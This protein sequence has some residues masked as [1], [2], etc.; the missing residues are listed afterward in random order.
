MSFKS[1]SGYGGLETT[2]LARVGYHDKVIAL[3]W[4]KDFLPEIT[5]SQ[6]NERVIDCNSTVQIMKQPQ[7]G[8]W[9]LYEKN[10][11]L[12][13]N[14]VSAEGVCL[15]ICN[16]AYNAFKFDKMD[17]AFACDRWDAWE[18]MFLD[19]SYRTLVEMW[20]TY[21]LTSMIL[22]TS[23]KNKGARAGRYGNI[24]LG[25]SGAPVQVTPATLPLHLAR[26]Q[27]V[28]KEFHRWDEGKMFI[29]V[30][31][32]MMEVLVQSNYANNA[33]TGDCVPCSIAIDGM[34]N[35]TLMGFKVIE[36]S[37]SPSA[38]DS[39]GQLA[40]YVI[41][42]NIDAYAWYAD[43]IEGRIVN[44]QQTFGIQYQMLSVWGGKM[45]YDDAMAI[46]YWTFG[47]N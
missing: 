10:Q 7:V 12:I 5:N 46:G 33:W 9:R 40:Y 28:L 39:T 35:K 29:V 47:E 45:L 4:E 44:M 18:S 14:Q 11:E 20:R 27:R 41:A 23:R 8:P 15:E 13:P 19:S 21:V 3:A 26:L 2:P 36:T 34:W 43:I 42:G 37:Y 30:P 24:N 22:E 25:T 1:A 17:I 16:A 32:A 6:I 38:V 31:T